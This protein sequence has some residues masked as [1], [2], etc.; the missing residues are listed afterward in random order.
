MVR[1]RV[2]KGVVR[3]N[4][5]EDPGGL[6]CHD[7]LHQRRHPRFIIGPLAH[8]FL[9]EEEEGEEEDEEERRRR[10]K[11]TVHMIG[12]AYISMMD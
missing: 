11:E 5:R 6:L 2:E 1:D 7:Q 9:E 3:V 8:L 4:G 10:R 12:I